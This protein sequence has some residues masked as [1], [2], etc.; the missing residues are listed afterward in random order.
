MALGSMDETNRRFL[1]ACRIAIQ[2]VGWLITA[3]GV[4][5][6]VMA[7]VGVAQPPGLGFRLMALSRGA[8]TVVFGIIALG[9]AQLIRFLLADAA[10]PGWILRHGDMFLYLYAATEVLAQ[11]A[12][13]SVIAAHLGDRW[14]VPF[15]ASV[16]FSL[17]K[18]LVLIGLGLVLRRVIPMAEESKT[19]V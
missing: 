3:G 7:C 16:P 10:K 9:L 6:T 13:Q 4:V 12:N 18:A 11:L 15:A 2:V 8:G 1:K 19:L 17:A 5:S 14:L